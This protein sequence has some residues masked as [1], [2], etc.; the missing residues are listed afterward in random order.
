MISQLTNKNVCMSTVFWS[1]TS[2][3]P[4][5]VHRLRGTYCLC[6]QGRRVSQGNNNQAVSYVFSEILVKFDRAPQRHI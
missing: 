5:Q 3:N 1:L 2:R 4:A 6:L